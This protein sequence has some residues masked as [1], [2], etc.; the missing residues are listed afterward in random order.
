MFHYERR[1]DKICHLLSPS[2][3]SALYAAQCSRMNM[4]WIWMRRLNWFRRIRF[5]NWA[6]RQMFWGKIRLQLFL[7]KH[8]MSANLKDNV[9]SGEFSTS[10]RRV[11]NWIFTHQRQQF[12]RNTIWKSDFLNSDQIHLALVKNKNQHFA[13]KKNE[14]VKLK[15]SHFLRLFIPDPACTEWK[16]ALWKTYHK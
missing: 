14:S 11:W 2:W 13:N 6:D 10:L 5:L 3:S 1:I 7:G 12:C 8:R 4:A 16:T 15:K 9:T